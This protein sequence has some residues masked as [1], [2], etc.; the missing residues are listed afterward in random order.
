MSRAAG[1][2]VPMELFLRK[3]MVQAGAHS[4]SRL[5]LQN[6]QSMDQDLSLTRT[7]Q[8]VLQQASRLFGE[9]KA[10]VL[11][12]VSE[13]QP[14]RGGRQASRRRRERG[15]RWLLPAPSR[16]SGPAQS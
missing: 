5:E 11:A 2:P 14:P 13:H 8:A 6:G 7:C 12:A 1:A 16:S 4:R 3:R 10:F 9:Q 15:T